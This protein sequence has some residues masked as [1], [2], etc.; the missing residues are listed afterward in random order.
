MDG[1]VERRR[2]ESDWSEVST[3]DQISVEDAVR[4]ADD[5]R[6]EL[7]VGDG[8]RIFLETATELV[9]R[10]ADKKE[11]RFRLRRGRV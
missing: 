7:E 9:V 5:S 6:A 4:T 10:K 11:T 2:G 3:G 1:T 8:S